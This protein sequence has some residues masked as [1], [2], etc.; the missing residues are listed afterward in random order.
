MIKL[1]GD[2]FNEETET[3]IKE[4]VTK[5][6]VCTRCGK[7]E[8]YESGLI[9]HYVANHI[10]SRILN[11]EEKKV[12]IYNL[13]TEQEYLIMY[14]YCRGVSSQPM[15]KLPMISGWHYKD[16]FEIKHISTML[17]KIDGRIRSLLKLKTIIMDI[18]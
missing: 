12:V 18:Q 13:K 17:D 10:E 1:I 2:L 5:H 9:Y 7:K 3:T 4:V 11:L 6:Y 16:G 14:T 8:S 15:P